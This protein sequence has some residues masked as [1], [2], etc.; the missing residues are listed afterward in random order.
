VA[1]SSAWQAVKKATD[2]RLKEDEEGDW[3]SVLVTLVSGGGAVC[4]GVERERAVTLLAAAMPRVMEAAAAGEAKLGGLITGE[5][6]TLLVETEGEHSTGDK[7]DGL[8]VEGT[9][10]LLLFLK[11]NLLAIELAV[12]ED[13][14][15]IGGAEFVTLLLSC[16]DS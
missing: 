9:L 2:A 7:R 14:S 13:A 11:N 12:F 15:E 5:R 1:T 16:E 8:K 6:S 3:E 10:L 4:R